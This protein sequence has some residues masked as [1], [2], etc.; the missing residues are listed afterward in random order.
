MHDVTLVLRYGGA[1]NA[2]V[3][4][5]LLEQRLQRLVAQVLIGS[6]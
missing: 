5:A 3:H 6:S 4:G 2:A 1:L